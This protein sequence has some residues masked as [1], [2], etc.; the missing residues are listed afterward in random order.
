M[1]ANENKNIANNGWTEYGRL[2][3]NK[4]EEQ[5]KAL[6]DFRKDFDEKFKEINDTLNKFQNTEKDVDDLKRW[7]EKVDEVWSTTQMKESKN[8]IYEQKSKW[9]LVAGVGIAVQVFWA[10]FILFKD[11]VI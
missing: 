2:V 11:N 5:D 8:E 10:L 1:P 3:L 9:L 4:L 6:K 7:K